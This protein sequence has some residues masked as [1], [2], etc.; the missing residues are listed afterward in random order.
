MNTSD[1]GESEIEYRI[2]RLEKLL[3]RRPIL[4]SNCIL[5]QNRNNVGEWLNR[6]KIVSVLII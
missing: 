1:K 2:L 3:E 5:R 4:L 6:I